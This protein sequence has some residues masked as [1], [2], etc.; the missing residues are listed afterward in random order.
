MKRTQ[1]M[2]LAPR[3]MSTQQRGLSLIE[4]MISITL[5]MLIMAAL[6]TLFVNV[7]R[8]NNEMTKANRQIEN[9]R[10][11]I[12]VLQSDIVH[13]GFWGEYVPPFDDLISITTG[14]VPSGIPDPC[15]AVSGWDPAYKTNLLG[16]PVQGYGSTPPSGTGCATNFSTNQAANTDVLVV[17]HAETCLPGMGNCAAY[18]ANDIYFQTTLCALQGSAYRIAT[19]S[20]IDVL[21]ANRLYQGVSRLLP[22]PE[23]KGCVGTVVTPGTPAVL[24]IVSGTAADKRK[25]VSNVYHVRNYPNTAD[26]DVDI[27]ILMRSSFSTDKHQVTQQL[28]EG[29]EA[30][31][32]EYLI[33]NANP[34]GAVNYA[35]QIKRVNPLT[36]ATDADTTKN[37]LP[38]NRGDGT[39]DRVCYAG[40][41]THNDLMN[42]VAVRLHVLARNLE[43]TLGYLDSKTYKLGDLSIDATN[44]SDM[45]DVQRSY[46]RHVFSTTVR[47]TNISGRRETP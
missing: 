14:E 29:I 28:I 8:T 18:D 38:S 4:L 13:A 1:P 32:V 7:T 25:F 23:I 26:K 22:L 41:C 15:M 31:R 10:F 16:I 17:R 40:I 21:D 5:G 27:P 2:Y 20:V 47:L 36:C 6:L 11:A 3:A 39:P 30:F 34:C 43:P 24:P 19:G 35:E 45:S 46:K 33:D 42:V 12:Q 37:T 9:G 44:S